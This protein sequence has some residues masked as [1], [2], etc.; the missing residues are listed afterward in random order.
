MSPPKYRVDTG[1]RRVRL[2]MDVSECQ[3]ACKVSVSSD[4][5]ARTPISPPNQSQTSPSKR[6][7]E[8]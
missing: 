5:Y 2:S 8:P 4:V 3:R 7:Q 1:L 6:A